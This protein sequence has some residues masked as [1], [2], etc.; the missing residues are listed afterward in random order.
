MRSS[1]LLLFAFAISACGGS[2]GVTPAPA[3]EADAI[4][5]IYAVQ[6]SGPQSPLIGQQVSVLGIVTGDFQTGDADAANN[7]GGF[8]LQDPTGDGDPGTS[9]GVFVFDESMDVD[10]GVGYRVLVRGT[11]IEDFGE[12]QIIPDS[13]AYKGWGTVRPM[14]LELPVT[15]I[16]EN[17][18]GNVIADLEAYEGMLVRLPQTL[19]VVDAFDL[20]RFGTLTL[21]AGRIHQF[22]NGSTPDA[23]AYRVHREVVSRSTLILDDGLDDESPAR[24][25]FLF[26]YADSEAVRLG[27][28]VTSLSGTLRY[29]RGSGEAGIEAYRL[30][31]VGEPPLISS[32]SRPAVPP[33]F[34]GDLRVM[35]FNALNFFTTPDDGEDSCG[36]DG[37][38]GCRGADNE[39]ELERQRAKLAAAILAADADIVGLMEIENNRSASLRSIVGALNDAS[40]GGW[41]YVSTGS[42]GS[43]AIRVGLVFQS[44]RV[45]TGG[46]FAVLNARVDARFNDNKNRPVLAQT[47]VSL[48]NGGR[49]TVVV[50][51]LKSK[52]SDCDDVGDPDLGDGQGNCNATRTMAATALA[53]W[54]ATDPTASGDADVLIIGDLNAYLREDPLQA[55]KDAGFVDTI[56]QAGGP[57]P[58]S[59]VFRGEAGALDHALA[60][61]SLVAQVSGAAEWHINADEPPMLDYNLD[62]GRDPGLFDA[63]SPFRA[64]DHDPVIVGLDLS[65]D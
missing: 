63:K 56:E 44:A 26:P 21:A 17:A 51:H 41:A 25:R 29:S 19:T 23:A 57:L 52:G 13:I 2:G 24:P 14:S 40:E 11:V 49:F 32:R 34:G 5:P 28:T 12:T 18:D 33:S 16:V 43:D 1:L 64:S 62:G 50:N 39:A 20:E 42:L 47:F 4:T 22:T 6:G 46:D 27:D 9:D 36:P 10:V 48:A 58:W 37:S 55:L 60:S 38:S 31:P 59:F 35:S 3:A 30:M 65:P 53:D 15:A 7:L 54:L 8:Y 45:A 61:A